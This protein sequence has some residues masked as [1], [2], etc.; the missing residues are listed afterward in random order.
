MTPMTGRDR[1]IE[2]AAF[3]AATA[4]KLWLVAGYRVA[5]LGWTVFDDY[6][7]VSAARSILHGEWLGR[8]GHMT[9]I[10]GP[11]YPL[12]IALISSAGLPLLFAQRLLYAIACLA[13]VRSL[14]P[15]IEG[16][17]VRI[18]LFLILL[19]NPS[20]FTSHIAGRVIREGIYPALTMLV[21]AGIIGTL[22]RL[23]HRRSIGWASLCGVALAAFWNTREEGVWLAPLLSIA[24]VILLAWAVA[25]PAARWR[26]AVTVTAIPILFS[27]LAF[28]A[29]AL[30]NERSYGTFTVV[31]FKQAAFIRAYSS[32]THVRK[33]GAHPRAPVPKE[34]RERVYAVSPAF[35]E[36]R[37]FLEGDIGRRW[38][39]NSGDEAG[40][41]IS[42]GAFMWALRDAVASAGHYDNG[43]RDAEAYYLRLAN[44]IDAARRSGQLDATP[45]SGT[46]VSP[47]TREG[48]PRI[49]ASLRDATAMLVKIA[50]FS[51][52]PIRSKGSSRELA[53]F[54]GVAH[55]PIA[56]VKPGE[57]V[58]VTGW[59]LH[60]DGAV[61]IAVESNDGSET[62]VVRR[63]SPDLYEHLRRSWKA[64]EPARNARFELW[65]PPDAS[66][67][68]LSRNGREL[69]R[70]PLERSGFVSHDPS[71]RMSI[72][73][74]S[75]ESPRPR[76]TRTDA[77]RFRALGA[78][79]SVYQRTLPIVLTLVIAAGLVSLPRVI[80]RRHGWAIPLLFAGIAGAIAV[81]LAI[82]AIIDATAFHAINGQYLSPAFPLLL[83]LVFFIA[84]E[85]IAAY[86]T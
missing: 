74:V 20:S 13:V 2:W 38:L 43:P 10:K 7:F 34:V 26:R 33:H 15:L 18:V 28:A 79:A 30:M 19:F 27:A 44:E 45:A 4:L 77:L 48:L 31:E 35:A 17:S 52:N 40:G 59:L 49:L 12:W 24:V 1:T 25:S 62:H 32:L 60:V 81:R 11:A 69:E 23:E 66:M 58:R 73:R 3:V 50:D 63:P 6:W 56:P 57:R 36:L 70:L 22:T 14:A 42:G 9:L 46:M 41:E 78:I 16:S 65:G 55:E 82:L 29:L 85:S 21:L 72:E 61:D 47:L 67:V 71:L 39:E 80:R 75:L 54:R 5:A 8:Y 51:A 68:V 86:R 37:P 53:T 64:F 84:H 76:I 83:V